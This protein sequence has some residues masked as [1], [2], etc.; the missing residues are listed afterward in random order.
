ML[1]LKEGRFLAIINEE[2]MVEVYA[3]T[4]DEAR[5]TVKKRFD[6]DIT[7]CQIPSIIGVIE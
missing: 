2:K 6:G 5:E 1:R 7:I 4:A 3:K